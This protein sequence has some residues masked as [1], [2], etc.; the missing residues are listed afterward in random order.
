MGLNNTGRRRSDPFVTISALVLLALL[1]NA[2]VHGVTSGA[3]VRYQ[4][5]VSWIPVLV[6]LLYLFDL[7]NRTVRQSPV[8]QS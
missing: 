1:V 8:Q 3:F 2:A 7:Y 5:K 4:A 6:A